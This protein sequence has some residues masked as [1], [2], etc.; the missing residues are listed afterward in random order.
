MLR[1]HLLIITTQDRTFKRKI[2]FSKILDQRYDICVILESIDSF[3]EYS[4]EFISFYGLAT[5]HLG[6]KE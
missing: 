1:Q 5:E 6:E 3:F 2:I 4:M